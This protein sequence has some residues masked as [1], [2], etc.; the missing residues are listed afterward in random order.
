M[1][2]PVGQAKKR[3]RRV[4]RGEFIAGTENARHP[5][6]RNPYSGSELASNQFSGGR[7]FLRLPCFLA[8]AREGESQYSYSIKIDFGGLTCVFYLLAQS[9]FRL[10]SEWEVVSGTTSRRS[11]RNPLSKRLTSLL[12]ISLASP[13]VVPPS[14]GAS[15]SCLRFR[16]TWARYRGRELLGLASGSTCFHDTMSRP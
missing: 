16:P 6:C 2:G 11:K 5:A 14:T 10:Q 15:L 4:L 7:S 8:T 9:S 13:V 3:P 1:R 12:S